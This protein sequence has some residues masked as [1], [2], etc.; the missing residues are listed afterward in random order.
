VR[1]SSRSLNGRIGGSLAALGLVAALVA[2]CGGPSSAPSSAG[3]DPVSVVGAENEYANVLAQ[4][5][6]RYVRAIAIMSNPNTDPHTFEASTV[7]AR[8]VAGAALIVQNGLGYDDFMARLEGASPSS[9]RIVLTAADIVGLPA[10]TAN[11]HIWYGPGNMAKVAARIAKALEQLQPSHR[12][13][14]AAHLKAFQASLGAWRKSLARLRADGAGKSVAVTEPVADD[15]LQAAG[16]RIAT[17]WAFQAAVMNGQDPAPQDVATEDALIEDAKVSVLVYNLQAVDASTE[18]LM[19]LARQ[20]Q[21]PVVGVY[22]TMPV[23][24]NYQRWMTTETE[25]LDGAI[26]HHRS[27]VKLP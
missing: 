1:A 22:E 3:R 5:G 23:G 18:S 25:A 13:Y 17:P 26:V 21:V 9:S 16:L 10:S 20:H 27:E 8:E 14:F 15:L 24:Y 19:A 6:G 4:I 2:G 12:A 7:D 11:P